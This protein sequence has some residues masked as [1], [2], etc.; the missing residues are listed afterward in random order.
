MSCPLKRKVLVLWT[1]ALLLL[2]WFFP[3]TFAK[4]CRSAVKARGSWQVS[5]YGRCRNLYGAITHGC[6]KAQN[7]YLKVQIE[8]KL[9]VVH[10]LVKFAFHGPPQSDAA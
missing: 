8:G 4:P 3:W 1:Y 7:G 2:N 9:Y 10:R 6:C 5:N